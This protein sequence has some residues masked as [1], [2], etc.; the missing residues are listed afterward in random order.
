MAVKIIFPLSAEILE[1]QRILGN[2][3]NLHG[4][5]DT[6]DTV[7]D[8]IQ[9][10]TDALP[11]NTAQELTD[12]DSAISTLDGKVV[13]VSGNV[14]LIKAKTD[15]LPA[16]TAAVLTAIEGATFSS[17]TDSLEAIRDRL[18]AVASDIVGDIADVQ[19]KLGTPAGADISTDI[20]A[21]KTVADGIQTDLSNATDG[22]GAIKGAVDAIQTDVDDATNGLAAIKTAV[23]GVQSDLDNS[24]DGLGALK[25][26]I[27]SVQSTVSG[28]QNNT[29]LTASIAPEMD[30]PDSGSVYHK[31][32]VNLYDSAGNK[33]DPDSE[34]IVVTLTEF[35]GTDITTSRL[36]KDAS[37]TALDAGT[38][39]SSN[40]KLVK[41]SAGRYFFF[42]KST[43]TD[44]E[45]ILNFNLK[46]QEATVENSADR[47]MR[48]V[49]E[50]G[51][52][53]AT[54]AN[55]ELM[56]GATFSS[57]TDSLEAL[58]DALVVVDGVVD[59]ISAEIGDMANILG[60]GNATLAD[61]LTDLGG[62]TFDS[63]TD[64]NEA[65]RDR[66][67]AV[68]SDLAGDIAD[69]QTK[70]GTPADTDV[71]TDIANLAA[72]V[73]AVQ[74]SLDNKPAYSTTFAGV[75]TSAA[76]AQGA[77][78]VLEFSTTEG[79]LTNNSKLAQL[80]ITVT[81]A[82]SDFDVQI[83]EASGAPIGNKIYEI[84]QGDATG[85]NLDLNYLIF[86]NADT[87]ATNKIYVKVIN[88]GD[89]STSTF[90]VE[91]RGEVSAN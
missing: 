64:S 19:T 12:I 40:K 48:I 29:R 43:S 30:R 3:E 66:L 9:V 23:V 91:L 7:V 18:D 41:D 59:A 35:D 49:Q 38:I 86:R 81:G 87:V 11:A 22:L 26:L 62:A 88:Q 73:A 20:A 42:Y 74:S 58:S 45:E 80:K 75:K 72:D 90:A 10:K 51:D 61:V 60:T 31:F 24:T 63:S 27:D 1:L 67:D 5:I 34:E 2:A 39:Y 32:F 53:G 25:V 50:L 15:N 69:V 84:Q 70:L 36:Y 52:A 57:S 68:A 6:I 76:L 4:K 17:S 37:G 44:A 55:Q 83:F 47:S 28:I 8:A 33:E 16:D 82:S 54:K 77:S 13:T 21:V 14:D 71:S 56:M 65:L 46:Y 85:I 79:V 89:A 78:E